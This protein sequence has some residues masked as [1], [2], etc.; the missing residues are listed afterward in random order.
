MIGPALFVTVFTIEGWLRAGYHPREM[1]V[2]ELSL[3]PRGWIQIGNFVITGLLLLI[4]ARGVAVEFRDGKASRLGPILLAIVALGLLSSGPLV[5]DAAATPADEMT[6]HSK[7]HWGIGG[8]VFMLGPLSCLVFFR[9]FR[10]DL[11]WR[12]LQWPTLAAAVI[13]S[14][15]VVMMT[16]GPTKPPAAPNAWNTWNGAMQR[17]FLV[18][19][20]GWIFLF[21]WRFK[22]AAR[23]RSA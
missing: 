7:L 18:F 14:L 13:T 9:R 12:A 17:T 5:M 20:L 15:V 23:A 4:F 19:Y 2:S 11:R 21:A 1:F 22:H 3:G 6:L 16:I 10:V 8:L